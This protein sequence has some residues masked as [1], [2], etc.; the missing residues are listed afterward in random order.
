M[1][2]QCEKCKRKFKIDDSRLA[3]PGG[4]VR[5]SKCGHIS[6][7]DKKDLFAGEP[8]DETGNEG[9][10][11]T[12]NPDFIEEHD[13]GRSSKNGGEPLEPSAGL[14][15]AGHEAV[16][17][18][19][20][21]GERETETFQGFEFKYPLDNKETATATGKQTL[22]S[23]ALEENLDFDFEKVTGDE[24]NWEE[25]V[26]ISKTERDIDDFKIKDTREAKSQESDFDWESLRINNEPVD[27]LRGFPKM[28]E[29]EGMDSEELSIIRKERAPAPMQADNP[30]RESGTRERT[31]ERSASDERLSV[32]MDVLITNPHAVTRTER[33]Q[34]PPYYDSFRM[35]SNRYQSKGGIFA[36]LAYGALTIVVFMV[37]IAASYIILSNTGIIPKDTAEKIEKTVE[38]VIPFNIAEPLKK[39]V[40]ITEHSGKW[41]NTRNGPMYV[42]SGT[43][44]ND[45]NH[46]ISYIKIRGEFISDGQVVYDNVAYAGNTFTENEL[47]S[48]PLPDTLLKLKKKSGNIDFYNPEKLAGLNSNIQPGESIPFYSVFPAAGRMLGLKYNL[49]VVDYEESE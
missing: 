44:K 43:V 29:D 40:I 1:I 26:S 12:D 5:C 41:L 47:K 9:V 49:E 24:G 31:Y 36:R 39:D 33:S 38:S 20:I 46:T 8:E 21:I 3:S 48:S 17:R 14:S 35:H 6:I 7:I 32:D 22:N 19:E 10:P 15:P 34:R 13:A 4:T 42:I 25:F 2:I 18:K 28:F 11:V 45:S 16:E 23:Q 37:I 30:P 27:A